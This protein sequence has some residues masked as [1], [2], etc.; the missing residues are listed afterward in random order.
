MV[1]A[2]EDADDDDDYSNETCQDAQYDD[3]WST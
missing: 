3:Q 2:D 1:A